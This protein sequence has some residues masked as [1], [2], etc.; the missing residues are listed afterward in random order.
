MSEIHIYKVLSKYTRK[1]LNVHYCPKHAFKENFSMCIYRPKHAFKVTSQRVI[2]ANGWASTTTMSIPKVL[3]I[4]LTLLLKLCS[5]T[6][7]L[8]I[9]QMGP[10]AMKSMKCKHSKTTTTTKKKKGST[11]FESSTQPTSS[12]F[13]M[14]STWC[15]ISHVNGGICHMRQNNHLVM[16]LS[17]YENMG[18]FFMHEN[19]RYYRSHTSPPPKCFFESSSHPLLFFFFHANWRTFFKLLFWFFTTFYYEYREKT[20]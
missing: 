4:C 12:S 15:W 10:L 11:L 3:E 20:K 2:H 14:Q 7:I 16:Y 19:K 13:P 1:F 5:T 18:P 8:L 9:L 17:F 6:T